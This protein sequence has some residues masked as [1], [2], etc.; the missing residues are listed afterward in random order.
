MAEHAPDGRDAAQRVELEDALVERL[1]AHAGLA[2]RRKDVPVHLG[3]TRHEI[4][5]AT[6]HGQRARRNRDRRGWAERNDAIATDDHGVIGQHALAIH[7]DHVDLR[8]RHDGGRLAGGLGD[9]DRRGG[10]QRG[11]NQRRRERRAVG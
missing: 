10:N 1:Q 3:E 6:F 4:T 5:V 2:L 7:R 9:R 11:H 8:E